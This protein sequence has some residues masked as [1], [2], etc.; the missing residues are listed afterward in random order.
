[1]YIDIYTHTHIFP[2]LLQ[3]GEDGN[4]PE[5]FRILMQILD[6]GGLF[7]LLFSLGFFVGEKVG[8]LLLI[9]WVWGGFFVIY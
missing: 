3:S 8:G 7:V 5:P 2:T 6:W 9:G 4:I 1:M